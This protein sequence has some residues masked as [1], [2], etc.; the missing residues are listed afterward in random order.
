MR[1]S[2]SLLLA[3]LPTLALA[4]VI[5]LADGTRR[6]GKVVETTATEVVVEVGRGGVSLH[7]RIP[8]G[9]VLRIEH[10]ASQ[11]DLLMAEYGRRLAG[12]RNGDADVWH[13]LGAWCA[14]QRVLK[15]EARGAFE[16]AIAVD[17]DHAPSH[18]ALGHVKLNDAWMT[19]ERAL[20]LLAPE[21]VAAQAQARERE[22][23]AQAA[24]EQAAARTAQAEKLV[25]ELEARVAELQTQIEGMKRPIIVQP[26]PPPVY[27]RPRIIIV[28]PRRRT[29]T[30]RTPPGTRTPAP[31][32]KTSPEDTGPEPKD[33][34]AH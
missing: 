23:A 16:R 29:P 28:P 19:R 18:A 24:A 7:V 10:K 3:V 13:A 26:P 33:G 30:T 6:E 21:L 17:P 34:K 25:A 5:H 15:I 4:D 11:N 32:T 2:L 14:E 9:D 22:L 1:A 8:R 20:A 27:P 31:P 12:A